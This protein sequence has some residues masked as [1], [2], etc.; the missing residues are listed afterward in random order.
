[1]PCKAHNAACPTGSRRI[2]SQFLF[3][4]ERSSISC[5]EDRTDRS[6]RV[7]RH[8]PP[9]IAPCQRQGMPAIQHRSHC[10]I[11]AEPWPVSCSE[12][13]CLDRGPCSY[14]SCQRRIPLHC[15]FLMECQR[16]GPSRSS[17]SIKS[18]TRAPA[19]PALERERGTPR[20]SLVCPRRPSRGS[21]RPLK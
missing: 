17:A 20:S 15:Y 6:V 9:T 11:I 5:L 8:A 13:C 3:A 21:L 4:S 7:A 14:V 1:M 2:A 18:R 16:I 12:P 10:C 19:R